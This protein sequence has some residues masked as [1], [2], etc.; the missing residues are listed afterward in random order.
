MSWADGYIRRLQ[1]GETVK[2]RPSG[3]SM[4]GKIEHRQLVTVEPISSF[5][6][7]RRGDIVLCRVAGHQYLHLIEQIDAGQ[8]RVLIRN[9]R[10]RIN[11]WTTYDKVYGRVTKVE[12]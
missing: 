12:P 3:Q 7:L 1:E 11:G 6:S 4:T 10:G 5:Y 9:N 8:K 2:F